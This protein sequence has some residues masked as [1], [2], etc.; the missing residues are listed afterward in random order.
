MRSRIFLLALSLAVMFGGAAALAQEEAT[1]ETAESTESAPKANTGF[2]ATIDDETNYI[3]YYVC[4]LDELAEDSCGTTLEE[5]NADTFGDWTAEIEVT[6]NEEGEFNHGSYV[7]AFAEGFEGPGKGCLMRH[8][9]QS[10]WGK[11]GFEDSGD[12]LVQAQTFCA[13]NGKPGNGDAEVEGEEVE[14]ENEGNGK[15]AWAGQ[16]KPEWAGPDGDKSK[17]PGKGGSDD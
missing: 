15:P 12:V 4:S 16:G 3:K 14:G 11:E 5:F 6:P 8:I 7:S 9:A 2:V 17:K 10:N 13:F 1:D